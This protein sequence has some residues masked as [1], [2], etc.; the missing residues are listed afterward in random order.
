[1]SKKETN[2]T[3]NLSFED[4]LE[5]LENITDNYEKGDSTLEKAV[6]LYERGIVLKNF[7]EKRLKEYQGK[8]DQIKIK[9]S[10]KIVEKNIKKIEE[11][12]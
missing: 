10:K 8:I 3:L 4:A 6:D 2:E 11:D 5:E 1:M 9:S 12:G 7:C